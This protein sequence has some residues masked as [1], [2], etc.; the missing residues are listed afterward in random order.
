VKVKSKGK[1]LQ[2]RVQAC[3]HITRTS[4]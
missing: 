3:R 1:L 2:G 4:C